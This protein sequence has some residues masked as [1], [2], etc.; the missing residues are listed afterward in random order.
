MLRAMAQSSM[1][2]D[3]VEN[4]SQATADALRNVD[5]DITR[6]KE[7]G[8]VAPG[9][10]ALLYAWFSNQVFQNGLAGWVGNGYARRGEHRVLAALTRLNAETDPDMAAVLLEAFTWLERHGA[11]APDST[12]HLPPYLDT[13]LWERPLRRIRFGLAAAARWDA[14]VDPFAL[15]PPEWEPPRAL[16]APT[17]GPVRYP[18]VAVGLTPRGAPLEVRMED[19]DTFDFSSVVGAVTRGL[20]RAGVAEEELERFLEE[21]HAGRTHLG[22]VCARWVSFDG[23]GGDAARFQR[24][25]EALYPP[26][27]LLRFFPGVKE[28][29]GLFLAPTRLSEQ[30]QRAMPGPTCVWLEQPAAELYEALRVAIRMDP[31]AIGVLR[32]DSLS[33]V[34]THLFE[35]LIQIAQT[36]PRLLV[37]GMRDEVRQAF[38]LQA[39]RLQC[40]V[41][42]PTSA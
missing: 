13:L 22:E 42:E 39:E 27:P 29:S 24:I 9:V 16:L 19:F 36:G 15:P 7:A 21:A 34:D 33:T 5:Y 6:W 12:R 20:W 40:P 11:G 32:G 14:S 41:Q 28:W 37:L 30:L 3:D 23:D 17:E 10:V 35:L 38:R 4:L 2:E 31:D 25:H 8:A 26:D 1:T 18:G